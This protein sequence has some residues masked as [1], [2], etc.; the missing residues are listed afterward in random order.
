M[1][2]A[3]LIL[4]GGEGQRI[5]GRKPMRLLGGQTLLDRAIERARGWSD[6]VALAVRSASQ[7]GGFDVDL[8][9]DRPGLEGPLGGLASAIGLDRPI[10]L[11]IA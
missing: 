11:T 8:L 2:P 10:V 4:A 3:I 6:K 5:G 7:V 9:I 1:R